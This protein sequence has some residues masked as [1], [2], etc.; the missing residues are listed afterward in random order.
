[1]LEK[2]FGLAS[3][4]STFAS[5]SLLH[6]FLSKLIVIFA[7]TIISSIAAGI[8]LIA[9]FY[10][11]YCLLNYYGLDPYASLAI[12]SFLLLAVTVML[13]CV[14]AEK[15]KNL[16]QFPPSTMRQNFPSFNHV[17]KIV[18]AFFDGFLSH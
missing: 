1:M 15:I 3:L 14:T 16:R 17:E 18:V 9:L 12:V 11:F 5:V 6:R 7:L 8:L 10:A 2:L 4:G 13:A